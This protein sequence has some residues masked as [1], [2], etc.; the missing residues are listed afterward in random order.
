MSTPMIEIEV[1]VQY[2]IDVMPFVT[3]FD[4]PADGVFR[5]VEVLLVNNGNSEEAFDCIWMQ[6]E[7]GCISQYG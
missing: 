6:T 3:Q 1:P 2:D 4:A 7:T 5:S